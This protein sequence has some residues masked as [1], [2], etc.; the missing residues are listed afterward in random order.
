MAQDHLDRMEEI[1]RL[2]EAQESS[3]GDDLA[4]ALGLSLQLER[5]SERRARAQYDAAND[6]VSSA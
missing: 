2:L 4:R 5:M 1:L 3:K 6:L